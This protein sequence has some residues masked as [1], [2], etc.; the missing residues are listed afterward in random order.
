MGFIQD[1]LTYVAVISSIA[2]IRFA[3]YWLTNN[4]KMD[5]YG[6]VKVDYE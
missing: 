6:G 5:P 1:Y 3:V 2:F 4:T